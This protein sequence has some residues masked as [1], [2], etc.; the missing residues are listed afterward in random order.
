[1]HGGRQ[2]AMRDVSLSGVGLRGLLYPRGHR[3]P[4]LARLGT[5]SAAMATG[6][7]ARRR[8]HALATPP[9]STDG[10]HRTR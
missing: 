8:K 6:A 7:S 9:H 5:A 1:M 3:R 4:S 10:R 2:R